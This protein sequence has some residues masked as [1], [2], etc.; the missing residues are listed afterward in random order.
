M[1]PSEGSSARSPGRAERPGGE[2]VC[3]RFGISR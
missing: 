2:E 1:R 3:S